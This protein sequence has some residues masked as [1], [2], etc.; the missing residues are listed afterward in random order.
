MDSVC[1]CQDKKC[2]DCK[3]Y[4]KEWSDTLQARSKSVFM[5]FYK[6]PI[7]KIN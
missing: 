2:K 1:D 4:N 6:K 7:P 5:K 3:A